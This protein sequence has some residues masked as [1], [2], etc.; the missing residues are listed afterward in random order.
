[1]TV[2]EQLRAAYVSSNLTV[3]DIAVASGVSESTVL[4]IFKG[5]NVTV[6]NL[7]AVAGVLGVRAIDVPRMS[8]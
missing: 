5:R 8:A 1:M 2:R 3:T 6:D 4:N 7:F